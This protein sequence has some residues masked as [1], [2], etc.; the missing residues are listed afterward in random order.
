[1]RPD[2][3]H[4]SG[5]VQLTFDGENTRAH[6]A[7]AGGQVLV[8]SRAGAADCGHIVRV[9]S[10]DKDPPSLK[11]LLAGHGPSFLPGDKDFVYAAAPKCAKKPDTSKAGRFLDPDLD[12][13]RAKTDGSSPQRLTDTPGYDAEASVCGKDGSI[14]FTSMRDGD[15]DVYRMD[16][17]GGNV[18]RL[19]ATPGYDGDASFDADC[20]RIVW[21]A[22]RPHGAA[23]DD[24]KKQLADNL[25]DTK[26]T[27]IW[28]ASADGSDARQVTYL[29]A[30]ALAPVWYPAQ[31]SSRRVLFATNYQADNPRDVDLW[32][33]DVDGTNLER[34]TTA[35]GLD[36]FPSFS[37]DGKWLAFTSSR[38]TILGRRDTNV[39]IAKWGN[40]SEHVE[41]RPA[42][43][44]KGDAA[45]LA[46]P[47]REGRGLG[48]KGLEDSGAYIE[49]SFKS[50][51]LTE[52]GDENDFRQEFEVTTKVV[53][54]VS[55]SVGGGTFD[56]AKLRSLGFSASSAVEG[57]LVYIGSND[58][59]GKVDVKG[60]IVVIRQSGRGSM[61]HTAWLARDGGAVGILVVAEGSLPE[62]APETNEGIAAAVVAADA[63]RPLLAML[64]RGQHPVAKLAVTLAPE[65]A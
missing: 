15:L 42:D 35:P 27:E 55:F 51:G 34:V 9:G 30:R 12:L 32:A 64:V 62:P 33:V 50:W 46:D 38:A 23:L 56:G 57:P 39:F 18:K 29:D 36:A 10:F 13:F 26:T 17:D 6:W 41:E 22:T 8:E 28:V 3:S 63:V 20:S 21:L 16:A 47:A 58:D 52:A 48:T 24:Y 25:L 53:G 45:W 4:L 14:V 49:R 60:K 31:V 19:T 40:A 37:P 1:V 65:T 59:F 2:E 54:Q 7:W 5:I 61:R 44:L 43:H 11:T